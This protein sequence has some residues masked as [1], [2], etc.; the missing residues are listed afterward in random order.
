MTKRVYNFSAGPSVLPLPVLEEAQRDLVALPEAGMS[1]LEVSHRSKWFIEVLEEAEANLRQLLQIPAN[2]QV[3]FLQGGAN[4]QFSMVP[5]N[6]LR[7]QDKPADYIITGSWSV[8]AMQEAQ[9]EGEVR[10][11]WNGKTDK[12]V[13]VPQPS[14]LTTDSQAAYVHF[15]S[16]E[17]I[18][19]VEFFTEPVVGNVPLICDM[20]S[21]FMSRP[22]DVSRYGLI[23]AGAQK[24]AGPAGVT[25]VIVRDDLL[26]NIPNDIHT[27][28]NYRI[29]AEK[30]SSFN[31]PPVFAIYM[32]MLVTRWLLNDIGGLEKMATLNQQKAQ[33][34]YDAVDQSNGFY[35]GH[36]Q[37]DSRS[38]MNVTFNLTT[39]ELEQ[40]FIKQA[41]THDLHTLKGHRSVGGVRASIYNAMPIEGVQALRDFMIEFQANS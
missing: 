38:I 23:Y 22:L 32:V 27:M 8:K 9:R 33:L 31:T 21:D 17:T 7:G 4:L 11:I 18:Q 19:G 10:V 36:A 40:A 30:K 26:E 14:E 37:P 3:L 2:Y 39:P 25:I 20:S 24:N 28:L 13:R 41:Q 6:L 12:F 5:I 1:I 29:H 35:R 34:L 15:T 16:N